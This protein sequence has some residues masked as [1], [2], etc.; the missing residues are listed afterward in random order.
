MPVAEEAQDIDRLPTAD[1]A[2]DTARV[3]TAEPAHVDEPQIAATPIAENLPAT[4]SVVLEPDVEAAA[5]LCTELGRVVD[6]AD[7]ALLLGEA[8]RV[9]DAVGLI[10][11]A[12]HAQAAAL[13]P[14][15]AHGYSD[16][17]LAQLPAVRRDAANAT[18]AAFRTT[19]PCTVAGSDRAS[20][21]LVAP[22]MTP[23]GCVGV[24]AIEL[25]L[26]REQIASVRAVVTIFAA[27]LARWIT[28][29]RP[30]EKSDRRLA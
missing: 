10:V 12:W 20:G 16:R 27:L 3:P 2:Q 1:E 13:T 26:G 11:W 22:L 19:Q 25:P 18:A 17:V 15:V 14:V 30:A 23:D 24:L 28:T 29:V 9:L 5:H 21:A 4:A 7:V 8:A 6:A